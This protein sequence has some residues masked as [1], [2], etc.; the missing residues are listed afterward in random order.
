MERSRK[1]RVPGETDARDCMDRGGVR[2][3]VETAAIAGVLIC[4]FVETAPVLRLF[5]LSA[6]AQPAK[7]ALIAMFREKDRPLACSAASARRLSRSARSCRPAPDLLPRHPSSL[8]NTT[9]VRFSRRPNAPF[10]K[11]ST[12]RRRLVS[13]EFSPPTSPGIWPKVT[14][15]L[16]PAVAV[17]PSAAPDRSWPSTLSVMSFYARMLELFPAKPLAP[18]KRRGGSDAPSPCSSTSPSKRQTTVASPQLC[19]DARRSSSPLHDPP[20]CAPRAVP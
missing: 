4:L 9:S 3:E 16:R 13:G 8:R 2:I 15:R 7:A 12:T 10:P 14:K 20:L 6:C 19:P 1:G 17:S 5:C 18:R 11:T